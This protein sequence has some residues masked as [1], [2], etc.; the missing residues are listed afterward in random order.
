[1]GK[2]SN[3]TNSASSQAVRSRLFI[4]NL[5]TFCLSKDDVRG[6]FGRYGTLEGVSMHRGYAFV[7]YGSEG[8]ARAAVQGEDGRV[9]MGQQIG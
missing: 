8:E 1:M 7:Q 9:Y 6:V 3:V 2:V 5:N 4:G